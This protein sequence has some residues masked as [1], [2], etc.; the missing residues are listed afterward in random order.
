MRELRQVIE[1]K[2]PIKGEVPF[3]GGKRHRRSL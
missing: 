2:Q 3:T 1:T